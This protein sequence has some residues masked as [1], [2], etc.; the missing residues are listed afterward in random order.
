MRFRSI[1]LRFF[2]YS[3]PILSTNTK[4][5]ITTATTGP[6]ELIKNQLSTVS[7]ATEIQ[8]TL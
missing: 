8:N 2:M 7:S 4:Y 1:G 5:I 6:G 3:G